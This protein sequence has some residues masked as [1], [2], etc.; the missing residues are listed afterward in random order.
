MKSHRY[1]FQFQRNLVRNFLGSLLLTGSLLGANTFTPTGGTVVSGYWNASNTG[2]TVAVNVP[3]NGSINYASVQLKVGANSWVGIGSPQNVAAFINAEA[4][5][6]NTA[7]EVESAT[8]FANGE[9]F[10]SQ[11]IFLNSSFAATGDEVTLTPTTT[12][13]QTV[14]SISSTSF[15][16]TSGYLKVGD[17]LTMTINSTETGLN[18]TT[19]IIN[20]VDVSGDMVDNGDNTYSVPYQVTEGDDPVSDDSQ[21]PISITLKDDAGNSTGSYTTSPAAGSSPGIDATTPS[22][23]SVSFS[24]A[25]GTVK[26][27][28]DL[29]MTITSTETGLTASV[30]TINSRD[31]SGTFTDNGDNTYTATYT[32]TE[33][34]SDV[35]DAAQIAISITLND[36]ATNTTGSYTTSPAAESS[37]GVDANTPSITTVSYNPTSGTLKVGDDLT[38]SV[39]ASEAGLTASAVTVNLVD[40]VST[41]TD[42]GGG[43]YSFTYTIGEGQTSVNDA[44]QIPVSV[45]MADAAGNSTG[46][47][48]TAPAAGSTPAVDANSPTITSVTLSPTSGARKV[49]ETINVSIDAGEAGLLLQTL[50]FNNVDISGTHSD[51]GGGLYSA[52]YTVVEEHDDISDAATI[53][54]TIKYND[55]AGNTTGNY[56]TPVAAG[57][58][59][60]IDANSPSISS[61]TFNPTAGTLKVGDVLSATI[62]ASESGLTINTATLNGVDVSSQITDNG[63]NTYTAL[64]T[65]A[66]GNDDVGDA[67]Q[68]VINFSFADSAGNSTGSFTTAPG[69]GSTPTIDANSPSI[70]S[71]NFT[72]TSGALQVGDSMTMTISAD[73]TGLSASTVTMNG[74]DVAGTLADNGDN[75]YTVTYTVAEG[76]TDID[77]ASTIPISVTLEDAAGNTTNTFTTS[78]A[79]GVTP[80]I[81]ANSPGITSVTFSPT[82]GTLKVGQG[83]TVTINASEASLTA[84][85]LTINGVDVSSTFTDN[86]GGVY[87]ATYTVTEGNT[88]RS[89][90][91][92]IPIAVELTDAAGNT[93][94]SYTTAPASTST[95]AVDANSPSISSVS[96]TPSSDTLKVGQALTMNITASEA[97]LSAS[98]ITVNGVNVASTL[99]DNGGGSYATTYTIAEGNT[100]RADSEQISVQVIFTDAAGNVTNTFVTAPVAGSTPAIDANTPAITSVSYTPTSGLLKVGDDLTATITTGESGLTLSSLTIN[101]ADV[102]GTIVDNSDG[103]YTATYTVTEGNTDRSDTSQIPISVAFTDAAGNSTGTYTTS[104]AAENSPGIDANSPSISNATLNPTSGTLIVDDILTVVVTTSEA[105]LVAN[106]ITVNG[107]DVGADLTDS[108][109]GTYSI[110]YT[111]SEGDDDIND[112]STIPLSITLEDAA[113]NTTNTYSTSPGATST[114]IIDA[115]SPVVSLVTFSPT[116]GTLGIG[117]TLSVAIVASEAGFTPD[118]LKIN[119]RSVIATFSDAGSGNYTARYVVVA[120]D[121]D[122][123]NSETIPVYIVLADAAGNKNSAFT[124]TPSS[125][126]TPAIDAGRPT[127]SSVSFA[128]TTGSLVPGDVLTATVTASEAGLTAGTITINSVNVA[129]S[130]TDN[131]GGSYT[132][133]YTIT[134]GDNDVADTATIPLSIIMNDAAG[135]ATTAYTTSPAAGSSPAIDANSPSIVSVTFA[136]TTGLLKVGQ[137]LT[138]NIVASEASLSANALTVNGQNV[139]GTLSNVSG[140]SYTVT[141]TVTEGENDIADE[142]TI[143]I[144]FILEDAAGNVTNTFTTS[145]AAGS[146]P[147]ID[148]NSPAIIS[149][150]YSPTTGTLVI[151]DTLTLTINSTE[152]GLLR[153]AISINGKT[154]TNFTDNSDNTYTVKYGVANGDTDIDDSATVPLSVVL[155]DVAGNLS[156]TN[157]TA[158]GASVTPAIDANRPVI[159]GVVFSPTTGTLAIDDTLSVTI[160]ADEAE[161]NAGAITVNAVDVASTLV[162]NG[163]NTYALTYT[164]GEGDNAISDNAQIPVSIVLVDNAGNS[165]TAFTSSPLAANAPGIDPTRPTITSVSFSPKTG[166]LTPDETLT[167]TIL[168]S[169]SG[170]SATAVSINGTDVT[171]NFASSGGGT[172]TVTYQVSEDDNNVSDAATIPVSVQLEDASGNTSNV[173]TTSPTA[174]N[175]PGIDANLPAVLTATFTPTSGTLKIG[176]SLTVNITADEARYTASVVTVNGRNLLPTFTD[177]DDGAYQAKYGVTSGDTDIAQNET[178]P[179]SI[180]LV[181]SAGNLSAEFTNTPGSASTPTIDAHAPVIS[182]VTFQPTSGTLGI[183]DSLI[184]TITATETGL[185]AGSTTVN[186]VDVST[187]LVDEADNTYTLV[188]VVSEGDNV[189]ADNAQIPVSI[190]LQDAAG[191]NSTTYTTSPPAVNTPAIDSAKPTIFSVSFSPTSGVLVPDETITMTINAGENGLSATAISVNQVSVEANFTSDGPGIYLVDYTI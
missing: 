63:N 109:G 82:S 104:P 17:N 164:V 58:S 147:A 123:T 59:P 14:P 106:S 71:V 184:V 137:T 6:T 169:E 11:V 61:V 94:G 95:P 25:S 181:D 26:V 55:T 117:D 188:Y 5:L 111:I 166:I 28:D 101:A 75:S 116:T 173:Y 128:P 13:D 156:S 133:T 132:L 154:L 21:I 87:T 139:S 96:F 175:S 172:Y 1:S 150:A 165:S 83:L 31:V 22:I 151:G 76:N 125:A 15:N 118:T 127:I 170:L 176:D 35:S 10:D 89:D 186:S 39:T 20:G 126:T 49:G 97:G 141:Y 160:T 48:T 56:T 80:S 185:T 24:P 23:S 149:L 110:A 73:E 174:G 36:A 107:V 103:T 91:E 74:V 146:S 187:T 18:A 3:N 155:K 88:D 100:D 69:S 143:P 138:A 130:L 189:I 60:G 129:S 81:D 19:L 68:I 30:L 42:N 190:V 34:D 37:P 102:S 2:A 159:S 93:T 113:G 65:I 162:D 67:E 177:L 66:E 148:A 99:V 108:G 122:V 41:K 44:S 54:L 136:P 168:A 64:Y 27:G 98:T 62:N 79:A 115:N 124:T 77:D 182:N 167:M 121:D 171:D 179:I 90:S 140:T 33:G 7:G 9:T 78:P 191:N 145:P 52:T 8:G 153:Q 40:V 45:T 12:I 29:T 86:T 85:T 70:S 51:D 43:S 112:S 178:I 114:P 119:Q 46:A 4:T 144:S 161:L 16:V 158:P 32:V 47:Y 38:L 134:E 72:P 50:T 105:G 142:A 152:T 157:T 183:G 135:N 131:G 120:G 163:D 53:P 84:A 180:T 92:E 57:S